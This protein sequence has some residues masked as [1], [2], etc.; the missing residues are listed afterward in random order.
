MMAITALWATVRPNVGPIV[1]AWKL[2][3]DPYLVAN[4]CLILL[5]PTDSGLDEIWNVVPLVPTAWT[6]GSWTPAALTIDWTADAVAGLASV[7]SM[8]APDV[9]SMPRFRPRPPI[10]SAPMSRMTPDSEK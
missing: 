5:L 3:T 4:A 1:R 10:A 2:G 7:A 6:T 9:K 8:R